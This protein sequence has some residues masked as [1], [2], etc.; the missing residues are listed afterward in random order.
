MKFHLYFPGNHVLRRSLVDWTYFYIYFRGSKVT[1]I[2]LNQF[3]EDIALLAIRKHYFQAE[4]VRIRN[5]PEIIR[6][7]Y[8]KSNFHFYIKQAAFAL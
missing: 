8:W 7:H 4:S 1:V 3:V 6:L 2:V 5:V